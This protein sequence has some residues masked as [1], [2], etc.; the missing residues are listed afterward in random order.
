MNSTNP[1]C[2]L[3]D[4]DLNTAQT[5]ATYLGLT[6]LATCTCIIGRCVYKAQCCF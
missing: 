5:I 6:L 4:H 1:E 2:Y 3:S